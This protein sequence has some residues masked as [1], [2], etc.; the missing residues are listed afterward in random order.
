MSA[1]SLCLG[2]GS[3]LTLESAALFSYADFPAVG[4]A[5]GHGFYSVSDIPH[6]CK[7]QALNRPSAYDLLMVCHAPGNTTPP[8]TFQ[9]LFPQ[10]Q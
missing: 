3:C 6:T 7:G 4:V 10:I 8:I 2:N 9:L 5:Q 1:P